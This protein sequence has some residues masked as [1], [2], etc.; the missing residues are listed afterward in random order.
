MKKKLSEAQSESQQ[1]QLVFGRDQAL[2]KQ[3]I[4]FLQNKISELTEQLDQKTT[5]FENR[6][7]IIRQEIHDQYQVDLERAKSEKEMWEQKLEQKKKAFK[8]S[9]QSLNRE[10]DEL[11]QAVS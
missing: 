2:S 11:E 7:S 3:S 6:I 9:E 10:K 4:E 1:N 5:L 8:E